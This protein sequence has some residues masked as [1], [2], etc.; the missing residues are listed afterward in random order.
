MTLQQQAT[1]VIE[2]VPEE[3][4][5]ML[6]EFAQFLSASSKQEF[7]VQKRD[8][9]STKAKRRRIA[10]R[11]KGRIKIASDFNDTPECFQEYM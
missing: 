7:A 5:P 11:L 10:G 2:V 4:L 3:K 9:L 6:I 1:E 8:T